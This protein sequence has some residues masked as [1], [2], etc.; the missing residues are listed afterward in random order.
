MKQV[1]VPYDLKNGVFALLEIPD[2]ILSKHNITKFIKF[3]VW[4]S[5]FVTFK[6]QTFRVKKSVYGGKPSCTDPG[7]ES[8]H[9]DMTCALTSAHT[10]SLRGCWFFFFHTKLRLI[11]FM[12]Y[13]WY[14]FLFSSLAKSQLMQEH[15]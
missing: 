12:F 4:K 10:A 7:V 11:I 3:R 13:S 15:T 14:S 2:P 6:M 5:S 9:A 8:R 1:I